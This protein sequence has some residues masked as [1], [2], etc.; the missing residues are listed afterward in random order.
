VLHGSGR[1]GHVVIQVSGGLAT[2]KAAPVVAALPPRWLLRVGQGLF[3]DPEQAN[4][5]PLAM[6]WKTSVSS[7]TF[8]PGSTRLGYCPQGADCDLNRTTLSMGTYTAI[9]PV[10]FAEFH[11]DAVWTKR[12]E[13]LSVLNSAASTT[14]VAFSE[15]APLAV[16]EEVTLCSNCPLATVPWSVPR[17]PN[18]DLETFVPCSPVTF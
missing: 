12:G 7:I 5:G 10:G 4:L 18:G 17:F 14:S 9:L 15:H 11:G 1:A 8:L 3:G 6:T 13:Q 16:G 2:S